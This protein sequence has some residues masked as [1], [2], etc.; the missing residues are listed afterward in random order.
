MF[1]SDIKFE[2]LYCWHYNNITTQYW[3]VLADEIFSNLS[4]SLLSA[5]HWAE[6]CEE[7]TEQKLLLDP[8]VKVCGA[9]QVRSESYLFYLYMIQLVALL[10]YGLVITAGII[11][12]MLVLLTVAW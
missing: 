12:N 10:V 4:S 9:G 7:E 5:E 2:I 3:Q 1:I 6:Q 11:G 8:R